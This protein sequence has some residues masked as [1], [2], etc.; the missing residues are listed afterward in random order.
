ME[1]ILSLAGSYAI[2]LVAVIVLLA[3]IIGTCMYHDKKSELKNRRAGTRRK[4]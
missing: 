4:E 3:C 2:F 1:E